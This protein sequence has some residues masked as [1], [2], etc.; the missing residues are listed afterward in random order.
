MNWNPFITC[1]ITGSGASQDVHPDLPI[2]PEQIAQEAA[3]WLASPGRLA[4][5]R[6]DLRSFR[7]QPGAVASLAAMVEELLPAGFDA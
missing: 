2:T 1:A 5:L 7:G 6:D 3:D 4:G